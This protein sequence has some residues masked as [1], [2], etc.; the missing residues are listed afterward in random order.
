MPSIK[1]II[2]PLFI[3]G[4]ILLCAFFTPFL[5][6]DSG[7]L[8]HASITFQGGLLVGRFLIYIVC[9]TAVCIAVAMVLRRVNSK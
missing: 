2:L 3:L 6:K 4:I 1:S 5:Q 8:V 9:V 7:E